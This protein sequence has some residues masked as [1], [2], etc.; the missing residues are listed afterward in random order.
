MIPEDTVLDFAGALFRS[1]WALELLLALKRRGER[2]WPAPDIVRELRGSRVVV[3]EAL[4]NLIAAGLV[5]QEDTGGYRYRAGSPAADELVIELEK[6][7]AAKPTAVIRKIV[8]SP[9]T[10]LQILSDAFR[11]KE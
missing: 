9:S 2:S 3:D 5:V 4:N 6:L 11:I 7:Y 10:K 8:T 1:V